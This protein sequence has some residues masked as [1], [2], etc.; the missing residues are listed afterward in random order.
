MYGEPAYPDA[1]QR[2]RESVAPSKVTLDWLVGRGDRK[3][4]YQVEMFE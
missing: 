3:T 4:L 2:V 1:A